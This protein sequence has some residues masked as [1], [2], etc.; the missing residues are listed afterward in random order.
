[1]PS[2][3]T[4]YTIR[5][6]GS[7]GLVTD[8]ESSISDPRY[9]LEFLNGV[10]NA[11]GRIAARNG[12]SLLTIVG[13]HS[14]DTEVMYEFLYGAA[15]RYIISAADTAIYSG[16]TTLTDRSD[17]SAGLTTPTASNWQF[18]TLNDKCYGF[19]TSHT[20]IV[21]DP[22][23]NT[24]DADDF[25]DLAP[26][27]GTAPNG[28][29]ACATHGRIFAFDA[30]M[31]TIQWCMILDD[32]DWN[33]AG[34]GSIDMRSVWPVSDV[35]VALCEWNNFLVVFG[36]NSIVMF[37]GLDDPNTNLQ[38]AA[39]GNFKSATGIDDMI[40]GDGL[41]HRDAVVSVGTDLIYMSRSGLR[42]LRRGLVN[43]KLPMATIGPQIQQQLTQDIQDADENGKP[44]RM[45]YHRKLGGILSRIG[46]KRWYFDVRDQRRVKASQW[47]GIGFFTALSTQEQLLL[48]QN[49]GVGQYA[50][51]TD[52]GSSYRFKW[53]SPWL[54]PAEGRMLI[55]KRVHVD[56]AS[57]VDQSVELRWSWDYEPSVYTESRSID[58]GT[59]A[60]YGIAEYGI[61]EYGPINA[62]RRR[63]FDMTGHGSTIQIGIQT[64]INGG[65]FEVQSIGIMGKVGRV[66]V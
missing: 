59:L 17:P 54:T 52:N 6:P 63:E 56:L 25:Q 43:E 24:Y 21:W 55:P 22:S 42:S 12:W 18:V 48:G 5:S 58:V 27:S 14:D 37:T 66:D 29:A 45:E 41:I 47:D 38:L 9:G 16:N 57:G 10:I 13:G 40:T 50:N 1:M 49:G 51:Y 4:Q 31:Q 20:P 23:G 36:S 19:Q 32:D 61:A 34:T 11:T 64:T 2:P 8:N 28:N 53:F 39:S 7:L 65:S 26:T 60:E 62:L 30:D 15:T 33:G 3:L 44:I 35:G 46:D